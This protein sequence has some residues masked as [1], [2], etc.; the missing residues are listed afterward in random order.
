[1]R[2][3]TGEFLPLRGAL[4]DVLVEEVDDVVLGQR[5]QHSHLVI[6][7]KNIIIEKQ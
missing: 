4:L 2:S 7:C 3:I 6:G 5:P 1:M